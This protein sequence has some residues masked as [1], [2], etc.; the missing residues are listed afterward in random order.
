MKYQ[1]T[2]HVREKTWKPGDTYLTVEVQVLST[3]GFKHGDRVLVT[4]EKIEK[5]PHHDV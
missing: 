1:T 5:K 3:D 4:V 2:E